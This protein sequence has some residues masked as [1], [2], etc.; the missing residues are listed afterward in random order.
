MRNKK[1]SSLRIAGITEG[2]SFLV[3]IC[4]AMPLKYY[5]GLPMAVKITGWLHGVLFI[6]FIALAWNYKNEKDK[7]LNWCD[8]AFAAALVPAGTFFFDMKLKRDEVSLQ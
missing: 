5:F 7:N 4:I 8:L 1:L 3:L 6:A 2:I